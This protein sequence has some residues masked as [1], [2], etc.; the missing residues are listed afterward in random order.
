MQTT[1]AST[2]LGHCGYSSR[3]RCIPST[4]ASGDQPLRC[5]PGTRVPGTGRGLEQPLGGGRPISDRRI[6][7]VSATGGR[8]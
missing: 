3:N 4:P 5:Q 6:L 8:R 1:T 2:N 7:A